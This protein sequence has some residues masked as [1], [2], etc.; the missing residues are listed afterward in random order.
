MGAISALSGYALG[1]SEA[2][3]GGVGP[4]RAFDWDAGSDPEQYPPDCPVDF[5]HLKLELT[6]ADLMSRSFEGTASLTM[7]PIHDDVKELTLNAVDLRIDDVRVGGA[8]KFTHDYDGRRLRLHFAAPLPMDADTTVAIRYGC[9]DPAYGMV[10][11]LPDEAYPDRPLVIHSQGE[12]EYARHWFPCLDSPVDRCSSEVLVTVPE[13]FIAISNGKLMNRKGDPRAKTTVFHYLQQQPHVFYLVSLVIGQFN[14]VSDKWRN[15]EVQYF[16]PPGKGEF[17]KLT[18]GKTPRMLDFFSKR[19]GFDYPYAKYSQVNVPLFMFGGMENTSA[20]TMSDS[21]I[22]TPRASIDQDLEGLVS[23][24]LAHQWFGDLITCRS[25]KHIWLNEGFAT[26]MAD[27]WDQEEKGRD[28]YLYEFW[29]RYDSVAGNDQA[30]EGPPMT[31]GDYRHP[32]EVFRFKGSMP[33]S[34]GS[35]VLHML[36]SMLGDELFWDGVGRY[37]QT[38]AHQQVETED[39]RRAMESVSG[40]NLEHFFTQWVYRP[41]VPHLNVAYD[42]NSG[43]QTATVTVRQTQRIDEVSPALHFPLPLYFRAGGEAVTHSLPV[44][45]KKE[46]YRRRFETKPDLF[47]VDPEAGVL[48]KT[49]LEMPREMWLTLLAQGPTGV[50]RAMAASHLGKSDRPEA[51]EALRS[52]VANAEEHWTVRAEA[53]GALGAMKSN[54]ARDALLGLLR[55]PESLAA[56][57]VR[58]AVVSAAGAYDEAE[59]GAAVAPFAEA[60]ASERVEASA[61]AALGRIR[62]FDSSNLLVANADKESFW[63]QIRM[64]AIGALAARNDPPAIEV[65]MKYAAYGQEDR[66]RPVAIRALGRLARENSERRAELRAVIA[67]WLTDPQDRVV[68]ASIEALADIGDAESTAAIR[69]LLGAAVKERTRHMAEDALA[70]ARPDSEPEGVKALRDEVIELRQQINRLR[71][72]VRTDQDE[73]APTKARSDSGEE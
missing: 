49:E 39:F 42:W 64:A 7:R 53:A 23:H 38:Y 55:E 66:L 33:Y 27:V 22:L 1:E 60:D 63:D 67:R 54:R 17:A 62:A 44:D 40:R 13:P 57:K 5:T 45:E 21:A 29:K 52:T 25:W 72:R 65:A 28:D 34:K 41:G 18:Y 36:R 61:T 9:V 47:C 6:F 68:W 4:K 10:W 12:A 51:V 8:T 24:E 35:C 50:T 30:G 26:F 11:A 59:V 56:H 70:R 37:I 14:E 20:T 3:V 71:D 58:A 48:S 2:L 73:D 19:L 15:V 16:L 32:D 43:E 31:F 46:V 69:G